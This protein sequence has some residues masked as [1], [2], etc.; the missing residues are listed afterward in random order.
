MRILIEYTDAGPSFV[1]RGWANVFAALGHSVAFWRPEVKPAF[2]VF[3]EFSPELFLGTTYGVD[4]AVLKCIQRRPELKVGLFCS[5]WGEMASAVPEEFPITRVTEAEKAAIAALKETCGNP[6]FVFSHVT[7]S[8]V[9]GMLGG[10]REIGVTPV[11]ILNAADT[12]SYPLGQVKP[13]LTCDV[14][15]I[16][17]WWEYKARNLAPY[18]LP[19]CHESSGLKVKIFGNQKWP[20]AQYLGTL[21]E[22]DASNLFASATVCPNISEPHST[23]MNYDI[24]ERPFKI[25]AAGGFCVSDAVGEMNDVFP[26]DTLLRASS[27][28]TFHEM[29]RH[30]VTNPEERQHFMAAGRKHVLKH[31]TYFQRV[32]Q[33]LSLF[34]LNEEAERCEAL[35]RKLVLSA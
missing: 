8:N 31:H 26:G 13:H 10:W 35:H 15:F 5:A 20:V 27:P 3:S 30:Y 23:V 12:F 14:G 11:G 2:D 17:G 4:R 6:H 19:L 21:D 34:G 25:L 16:G 9:E 28:K 18:M 24:V 1:R 32:Q 22:A 7:E 29:V 33:M